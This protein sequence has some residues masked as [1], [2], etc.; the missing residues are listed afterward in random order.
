MLTIS[1]YF[2]LFMFN[3]SREN[4]V[5]LKFSFTQSFSS[6]FTLLSNLPILLIMA[7]MA[8]FILGLFILGSTCSN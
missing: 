3:L 1:K 6:H 5:L 8:L 4:L 2:M 7:N